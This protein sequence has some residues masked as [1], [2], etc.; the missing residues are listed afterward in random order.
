MS[1]TPVPSTRRLA[2]EPIAVQRIQRACDQVANQLRDLIVSGAVEPG[3]R[4]PA[5]Q[6]L[7]QQF[8]VSRTTI[9]EALQAF[10]SEGLTRT[11]K[12]V[13]GG[14][15]VTTPS[16]DHVGETLN[17]GVVLLSRSNDITLDELLEVREFLEVPACELAA[18]RRTPE[19]L[20]HIRAAVPDA[21]LELSVGEQYKSN[22]EFHHTLLEASHNQ[23]LQIS[24]RPIFT[25]L[26]TRLV[27]ETLGTDFH[28]TLNH[29]HRDIAEA[30]E[31]GNSDR[32][33]E[34]MHA[35]L[36][37]LR[38]QHEKVWRRERKLST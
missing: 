26:Q 28:A 2:K 38:P 5:E 1:T 30:V 18:I 23:L 14:T 11:K 22:N 35:H 16:A 36:Q 7:A 21:P 25:V 20:V 8:G 19:D 29:Q 10:G 12:G 24:A 6:A 13:N 3:T 31:Q 37:W 33:G 27:R 4:F 17:S 9:R 32:A 15:F 34:L